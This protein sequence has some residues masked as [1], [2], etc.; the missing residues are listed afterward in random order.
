MVPFNKLY[1]TSK[2]FNDLRFAKDAG[3]GPLSWLEERSNSDKDVR[4]PIEE[5]S[6]PCNPYPRSMRDVTDVPFAQLTPVQEQK[7]AAYPPLH[8]HPL[9]VL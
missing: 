4:R 5:G 6:G 7:N 1:A 9:P 8:V 3:R 2:E